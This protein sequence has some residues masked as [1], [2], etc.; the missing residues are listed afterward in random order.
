MGKHLWV[1][2]DEFAAAMA[3]IFGDIVAASDE[4]VFQ[5]VHDALELGRDEWRRIAKSY[6]AKYHKDN[7]KYG[8]HVTYRTLRLKHGVEGHIYSRKAGLPHLLEKGHAKIG[9]GRT[10]AY[11][12]VKPAAEYAFRYARDHIGEYVARELR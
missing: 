9:G 3:E 6:K 2:E 12:H 8:R 10:G 7:W 1:E 5:C 4:A 11:P